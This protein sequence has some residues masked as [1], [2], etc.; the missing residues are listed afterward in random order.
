MIIR[1]PPLFVLVAA[2][3]LL[4][5]S[6]LLVI[7]CGMAVAFGIFSDDPFASAGLALGAFLLLPAAAFFVAARGLGQGSR[8]AW[9][10]SLFLAVNLATSAVG[11]DEA[12]AIDGISATAGAILIVSLL[13]PAT[14]RYVW[15]RPKRVPH[16]PAAA[17]TSDRCSPE[18]P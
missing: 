4:A 5:C 14:I 2:W 18:E 9:I 1:R 15:Q 12:G 17:P 16:L 11:E 6:A 3:V 13:W 7:A 8:A 10:V